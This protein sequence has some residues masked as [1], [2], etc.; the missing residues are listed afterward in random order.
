[1]NGVVKY[2][3]KLTLTSLLLILDMNSLTHSLVRSVMVSFVCLLIIA[4]TICLLYPDK[5]RTHGSP[6][7]FPLVKPRKGH[8]DLLI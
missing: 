8:F 5:Y 1:M 2:N 6:A 4:S 7:I 3:A